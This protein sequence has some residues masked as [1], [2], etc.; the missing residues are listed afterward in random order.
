[1]VGSVAGRNG[2]IWHYD[3]QSWQELPD[4]DGLPQDAQFHD[5]PAFFKVWGTSADDVW[6]V[7]GGGVVLRGNARDGCRVIPSGVQD[8][9]FTVHAAAGRVVMV[10]G[11]NQ[12]IIL[13]AQGDTLVNRAP[14][15]APL[16]QGVSVAADGTTWVTGL[17]GSIYRS[18]GPDFKP[19]DPGIDFR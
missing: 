19:V 1:A 4:P 2:F 3:G 18:D 14:P 16:L 10:G 12:G 8:T 15:S 11:S 17:G 9:L 5:V 7:G 13:E 6:V